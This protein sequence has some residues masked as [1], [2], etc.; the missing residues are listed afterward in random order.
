MLKNYLKIAFR[1]LKKQKIY[2]TINIIGLAVGI[3]TCLLVFAYSYHELSYDSTHTQKKSIFRIVG[4]VPMGGKTYNNGEICAPLISVAQKE[5]PEIIDSVRLVRFSNKPVQINQKTFIKNKGFFTEPEFFTFFDTEFIHGNPK[6]ALLEPYSV[7]LNQTLARK[8]FGE[9]N[10]L[11]KILK[12]PDGKTY[13]F[14]VTGVIKDMPSNSVLNRPL[15]ISFSTLL[16]TNPKRIEIWKAWGWVTGFVKLRGDADPLAIAEKINNLIRPHLS[17]EEKAFSCELERIQD[18]YLNKSPM[19]NNLE[20]GD[21]NR[22]YTFSL[23]AFLI[24]LV[25]VINFINL[26]TARITTRIKEVGIYKT[27]GAERKHLI[28][29]FFVES[30]LITSIS[31]GL[32]LLL[33]TRF[34]PH[35]EQYVGK[36]LNLDL[37]QNPLFILILL[38]L[39]LFISLLSGFFPA[40]YFTRFKITDI[41]SQRVLKKTSRFGFRWILIGVQFFFAIALL[42]STLVIFKQVKYVENIDLGY[43]SDQLI[44]LKNPSAYKLKNTQVIKDEILQNTQAVSVAKIGWFPSGQSRNIGTYQLDRTDNQKIIA[45]NISVDEDFVNT[46]GLTLLK[47]RMFQKGSGRNEQTVLLNEK[48]VE[49]FGIKD[50]VGKTIYK[51]GKVYTIVGVLKSWNTNSIHSKI[52]SLVIHYTDK[53]A[54]DILIR[55]NSEQRKNITAQIREVWQKVCPMEIFECYFIESVIQKSYIR[56][57][58]LFSLMLSLCWLIIIIACMGIVGLASFTI[59]Q[60]RKEIGIRKILGAKV[61][62][63]TLLLSKTYIKSIM[64]SGFFA[65]PIGYYAVKKWLS[66]FAFQTPIGLGVFLIPI[67]IALFL[68]LASVSFYI[69]KAARANPVES[70]KYE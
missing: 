24:L 66:G 47:G 40:F 34:K 35:L 8:I 9:K 48:A 17:K 55:F 44:L 21:I 15:L 65:L 6:L 33:V 7:V 1:N 22:I 4:K 53:T 30:F 3:A 28:W 59:E 52:G 38:G 18:I 42:F 51:D 26:S 20:S 45:Q 5:I 19:N 29:R 39:V 70:L 11:G 58:R 25:A 43:H 46:M 36:A 62:V 2:T 16:Q 12:I 69:L 57:K 32:G 64:L 49:R 41:L 10:P 14:K 13:D 68:S 23:I 60:R 63:L 31:M 54:S 56:E 61:S 67:L 50:P 27:H 37:F